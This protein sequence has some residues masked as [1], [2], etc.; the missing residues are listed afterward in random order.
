MK[1]KAELRKHRNQPPTPPKKKKSSVR[2]SYGLSLHGYDEYDD[3]DDELEQMS[4]YTAE[5]SIQKSA[6]GRT[7]KKQH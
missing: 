2:I 6:A 4:F 5:V 3:N 7:E 1:G